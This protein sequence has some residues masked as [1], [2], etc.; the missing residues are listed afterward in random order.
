M[1]DPLQESSPNMASETEREIISWCNHEGPV[2]AKKDDVSVI[3]C[4]QCEFSHLVPL[5][6]IDEKAD[7]YENEFYETFS[8]DYIE[9][10]KQDL[11]WWEIEHKEKY[12]LFESLLGDKKGS[13]LDVGSGPGMFLKVGAELGWNVEGI[14]PGKSAWEFSTKTL[15]L[16]VHQAYLDERNVADFGQYDVVHL[17]NVLEHT[18]D[19]GAFVAMLKKLVRPGGLLVVTVPNDFNP[20]QNIVHDVLEK[21]QWW[22][23]PLQHLNYFTPESLAKCMERQGLTPVKTTGSFPLELFLLMGVDYI[24]NNEVGRAIHSQRKQFELIMEQAGQTALKRRMYDSLIQLGL[25]RQ[26]TVV[27]RNSE[28]GSEQKQ[29]D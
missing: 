22:V 19:A 11:A 17:N 28:D 24:G 18:I 20:L 9:K 3:E 4:K 7:F 13:L 14:E 25:G 23:A 8:D 16:T 12:A 27:A 6:E 15:G 2:I 21:P 26:V 5:P 29:E 10:H 1:L